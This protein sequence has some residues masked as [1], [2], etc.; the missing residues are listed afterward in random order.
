VFS[1]P[2]TLVGQSQIFPTGT[3][4]GPLTHYPPD[5]NNDSR[6]NSQ[7]STSSSKSGK[8]KRP[9]SSKGRKLS[10][11]DSREFRKVSASLSDT[12][13]K[14]EGGPA[15]KRK[16]EE[17]ERE[18]KATD[19]EISP[20]LVKDKEVIKMSSEDNSQGREDP[21]PR[22]QPRIEEGQESVEG[23]GDSKQQEAATK[24]VPELTQR[25]LE[26]TSSDPSPELDDEAPKD[27]QHENSATES[28][29]SPGM[30]L[31]QFFVPPIPPALDVKIANFVLQGRIHS[32]SSDLFL[33]SG[34]LRSVSTAN[35]LLDFLQAVGSSVPIPKA[36][37]SG[38]LKDRLNVQNIKTSG[39]SG[40]IPSI[41]R[42]VVIAT[43]LVWLWVQHKASFQRAFGKSGRIDVDPECKWLIQAAVDSA[44]RAVMAKLVETLQNGGPL[45]SALSSSRSKG[46]VASSKS[47]SGE[48][49]K[50]AMASVTV[51]LRFAMITNEALMTELCIDDEVDSVLPMYDEL[52]QLLDETRL[53]ALRGKCRERVYLAAILARHSTMAEPFANS[54]VSCMVRAGEALGHG[55]LF[56]L[57]QDEDASTSTMIPYDIFSDETG[58][59]EDPCRPPDGFTP[60]LAGEDLVRRAHA[61]AMI[62]KS[63]N[64]MQRCCNF[65]GGTDDAGPYSEVTSQSQTIATAAAEARAGLALQRTPSGS[66]KR[67]TS[68]SLPETAV[69][70][71]TGFALANSIN[72]YNPKHTC[73]PLFWDVTSIENKPYGKHAY[74]SRPRAFS[75][76]TI[77]I[78]NE[79]PGEPDKRGRSR[80]TSPPQSRAPE[81]TYLEDD[82][83]RSTEEIAWSDVA[84]AFEIVN[85]SGGGN[86][87]RSKRR[88]SFSVSSGDEGRDPTLKTI[89]APFCHRID[90]SEIPQED[91][92][93]SEGEEDLSDEAILARHQ[94]VLDKMKERLDRF[95]EGRTTAGQRARQRAKARAAEKA[96][97]ADSSM[98]K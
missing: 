83:P 96:A 23:K 63:L 26:N 67:R 9:T 87:P 46:G 8:A 22:K 33:D 38:P 79:E 14:R 91:S 58:A 42:E 25:T 85:M 80:S 24:V 19:E 56:E 51:D 77:M 74:A 30:Q 16:A 64:K 7:H 69:Q 43:I 86:T 36:L 13:E 27:H 97:L 78:G 94:V 50:P 89:I 49:E 52:V 2:A 20:P 48:G 55:E 39:N 12:A 90:D 41:P 53:E 88:S 70:P 65:K 15:A 28:P 11:Q 92:G 37:I 10:I 1:A 18:V 71:G 17:I 73:V 57:V 5:S 61:R 75:M 68:F 3:I 31:L 81:P 32:A 76:N 6:P 35:A 34:E 44:S 72:Q 21:S 45:A 47:A 40:N 95:M 82:I 98:G 29:S 84:R 93:D 62:L 54:Y 66:M 4:S 60:N 59:W